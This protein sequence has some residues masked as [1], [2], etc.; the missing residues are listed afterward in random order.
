[1]FR[2][3]VNDMTC[4]HC[5]RSI[6]E[7]VEVLDHEAKVDIDLASRL[8]TVQSRAAAGDVSRAIQE[9]GYNPTVVEEPSSVA[10]GAAAS[11]RQVGGCC[12]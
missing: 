12:G 3:Q 10:Q 5:V 7:A 9:A 11:K 8:V 4:G 1:M 6:T 2:F